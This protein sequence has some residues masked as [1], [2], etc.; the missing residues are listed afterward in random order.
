MGHQTI[1]I[2]LK[3]QM[4]YYNTAICI[5]QTYKTYF[6]CFQ[7][8]RKGNIKVNEIADKKSQKTSKI[9]VLF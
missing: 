7:L 1:H 3:P 9:I 5:K 4:D 6:L 8:K 2:Q